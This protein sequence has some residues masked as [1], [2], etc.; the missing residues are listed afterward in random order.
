MY[1]HGSAGPQK[2]HGST[3]VVGSCS[4]VAWSCYP[5]FC[6]PG[7]VTRRAGERVTDTSVC[8]IPGLRSRDPA[9][10][11]AGV[12]MVRCVAGCQTHVWHHA[13]R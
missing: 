6:L 12:W 8:S 13:N 11:R 10:A 7:C 3:V 2:A 9:P 1:W 4:N 5:I